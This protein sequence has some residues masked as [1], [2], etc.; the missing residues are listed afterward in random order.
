MEAVID[1]EN[2]APRMA[3]RHVSEISTSKTRI[4]TRRDAIKERMGK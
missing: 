4:T 1:I 2:D 3:F